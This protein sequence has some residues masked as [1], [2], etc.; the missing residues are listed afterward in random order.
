MRVEIEDDDLQRLYEDPTF[1][2]PRF[3]RDVTRGYRRRVQDL[4][5]AADERDLYAMRSWHYEKLTGDRSGQHSVRINDQWRLI[6]R[7]KRDENN[8][9]V[10]C[11]VEITDYH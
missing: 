7:W 4:V 2:L 10:L 1:H 5:A 11:V 6:L 3:G 8:D 9:R